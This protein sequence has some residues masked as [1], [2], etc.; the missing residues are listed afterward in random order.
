MKVLK[1]IAIGL[2]ALV[3]LFSCSKD[4]LDTEYTTYLGQEEAAAAAGQNPDV[5]LNGMWSWMVRYEGR[6]DSYGIYTIFMDTQVMG[7]DIAFQTSSWYNFDYQLDY[8]EA[9]WVRT[10]SFWT[11][12][13]TLIAKANEVISLY[14]DGGQTAGEKALLGQAYA[15]RGMSY[16]YLVQIYQDYLNEDGTFKTDAPAI[17]I[18]YNATD[19]KTEAQMDS[20]MGRNTVGK[21]LEVTQ[22]DLENAVKQLSGADYERPSKNYIDLSVAQGLLARFYLLTQQWQ[23]AADTA[24]AARK[25]Y[26]IMGNEEL[27]QGFN[28]VNN[29]EWMWGFQHTTETATSYAS[30]FSHLATAGPGY[31]ATYPFLIDAKLYSQIPESDYRKTLFNGPDGDPTQSTPGAKKP[32]ANQKFLYNTDWL[33]DYVY[34]RASEMILIEAEAYAH[35]N[36]N[37]K[38]AQVLKELMVNRQ[39]DWNK[40]LVTVEDVYL[41]RRI[42]LWGEGFTYFD[43]KRLNK[44]IDRSYEGNNHNYKL[45]VPAHSVLWT[46]QLPQSELQENSHIQAS[47]QNP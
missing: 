40:V 4:Y 24:N 35:L 32:Y 9:Q 41:Q 47:E 21:V 46:F 10:S 20:A 13:Y 19:G 7:E 44:G 18:I 22:S 17:P 11:N 1:N 31:G 25:G 38:A 16:Y 14:P 2:V 3:S 36:Q 6:H 23:K 30:L 26:K 39:P 45:V 37:D 8:R 5:F 33:C 28:S 43:L 34:M 12:L 29:S 42:E 15:I 27:H